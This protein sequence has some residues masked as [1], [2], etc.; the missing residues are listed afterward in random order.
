MSPQEEKKPTKRT[1]SKR[2]SKHG[3]RSSAADDAAEN[4][5]EPAASTP[6]SRLP[7]D[8]AEG[9]DG[10]LLGVSRPL[11]DF[12]D[13]GLLDKKRGKTLEALH[14][15]QLGTVV[16]KLHR[17]KLRSCIVSLADGSRE[18]F[19]SMDLGN[20]LLDKLA[21]G[22]ESAADAARLVEAQDWASV[23]HTLAKIAH[24]PVSEA[25]P[26][27]RK[28]P[29]FR[30]ADITSALDA[31]LPQLI[32][33]KWVPLYRG[34]DLLRVLECADILEL[35]T[36]TITEECRN[37]VERTRLSDLLSSCPSAM[38]R[39]EVKDDLSVI[40]VLYSMRKEDVRA[41]PVTENLQRGQSF[42]EDSS[43]NPSERPLKNQ[44]DPKGQAAP[45]QG[46]LMGQFDVTTL[47]AL[48]VGSEQGSWWWQDEAITTNFFSE[49]CMDFVGL[50]ERRFSKGHRLTTY[51]T[52]GAEES[53]SRAASRTLS[54]GSRCALVNPAGSKGSGGPRPIEGTITALGL[55][56][57]MRDLGL[58]PAMKFDVLK[59]KSGD[60]MFT[61]PS[62]LTLASVEVPPVP[63]VETRPTKV[64][65]N[66]TIELELF[67]VPTCPEH[68]LSDM[69]Y[70]KDDLVIDAKELREQF[71]NKS[72][73]DASA[74]CNIC[75]K[76]LGKIELLPAPLRT[77]SSSGVITPLT[78]SFEKLAA[79]DAPGPPMAAGFLKILQDTGLTGYSTASSP[80]SSPAVANGNGL[81]SVLKPEPPREIKK[82]KTRE[83]VD[84]NA[85]AMKAAAHQT[86]LEQAAKSEEEAPDCAWFGF[87]FLFCCNVPGKCPGR[88]DSIKTSQV[89]QLSNRTINGVNDFGVS[90]ERAPPPAPLDPANGSPTATGDNSPRECPTPTSVK[91]L[92]KNGAAR[93]KQNGAKAQDPSDSASEV[94][95]QSSLTGDGLK[96]KPRRT[97]TGTKGEKR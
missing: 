62:T 50:T 37:I 77:V 14:S 1:A 84:A 28:R 71:A 30:P 83:R 41:V 78:G 63:E 8:D 58:F 75:N 72:L 40:E 91:Q 3:R 55:V 4:S 34:D 79:V 64:K 15:D 17:K 48:F 82:S 96:R 56:H 31:L 16:E 70:I 2:N 59:A 65:F 43:S 6:V 44:K 67:S 93:K 69:K 80:S 47:R 45:E 29:A 19:D 42:K 52:V 27:G 46:T 7:S 85:N 51:T 89:P 10:N 38:S 20:F 54:S 66:Y 25:L 12:L 35:C 33:D 74:V 32:Q 73:A 24:A 61:K 26:P 39:L 18:F 68:V 36:N 22:A 87:G 76:K 57:G 60:G 13:S 23:K 81:N 94:S 86:Q 11:E 90:S 49:P 9:T 97:S 88:P 5:T 92:S 53:V 95:G 21:S